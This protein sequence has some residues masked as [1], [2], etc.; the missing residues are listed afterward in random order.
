MPQENT[1]DGLLRKDIVLYPNIL[2]LKKFLLTVHHGWFRINGL[3][4]DEKYSLADYLLDEERLIIDFTR[5]SEQSRD[6][7]LKW[8][9]V[10]HGRDAHQELLSGVTTNNYRGYTA[11]VGLSWWGKVINLLFYRRKSYHWHLASYDSSLNHQITGLEVCQDAHGLLIGLK[12][13]AIEDKGEK[14]HET[15]DNQIEPLR[16]TKR[17]LITDD[18][19]DK[20]L[21]TDLSSCDFHSMVSQPHPFSIGVLSN[22]QRMQAMREYRQTQRLFSA[23]PWYERLWDWMKALFEEM[24]Q[25]IELEEIHSGSKKYHLL[26]S[27]GDVQVFKRDKDGHILVIEK[28]PE[29]SSRVFCGGGAKIFAHVGA[30]K[31]FEEVGIKPSQHAGSSAGAIMAVLCYLGYSSNDILTFFQW[32]KQDNLIHYDIDSSGLS[33][34]RAMKAALD[35]MITK[36]VNEIIKTYEVDKT[37]EG[38]RFL[39][40]KVFKHGKITFESLHSLKQRIPECSLGDK[41]IVTAT[42][43]ERRKTRYFS[44]ATTPWMEVSEAVK[45]SASFPLVFKPTI[46]EGAKHKDGGILNNLPTEAFR[47]DLSTFL[48][49]EHGNCLSMVAFQFDNGYERGLLDK[50][51]DRVYRE[52]FFWNWIYGLLTGVRDPVSGWERDRLKLLQHSNQ[53]VLIPVGNVSSTQFDLDQDTQNTLVDNGYKAAKNYINVRYNVD[54][55]S[56]KNEEHM[57]S[58]FASI[59]E[60][61]C[62]CCYRGHGTW[63]ERVALEARKE[64]VEEQKIKQLRNQHFATCE[65]EKSNE[66]EKKASEN[67]SFIK[68]GSI[69]EKQWVIRN[70][71]LF[72]AIYP[73]FHKLSCAFLTTPGDINLFK[74]ARHS[75]SLNRPLAG[76]KYLREIKGE[77]HVLLAMFIQILNTSYLEKIEEVVNKLKVLEV[78]LQNPQNFEELKKPEFYDKWHLLP[79]QNNRILKLL[80]TNNWLKARELCIALKQGEEPLETIMIE[81]PSLEGTEDGNADNR[82]FEGNRTCFGV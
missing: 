75:L 78:V 44:Y 48:E 3:S 11:E 59:E 56:A 9:L 64:G 21:A 45:T 81:N 58:T 35:Y 47:G 69:L 52:N 54:E 25:E 53:V 20:L 76:L 57:Y 17:V 49:S 46:V 6:K 7:F 71:Q 68:T 8:F 27:E 24:P 22:S 4:P 39:A 66:K 42:N 26:F 1:F 65:K 63:F 50:F 23:K 55:G 34:A 30:I 41:L 18:M 32:F 37:P 60:L 43:V 51:V 74:L 31:A 16:N 80:S 61:L 67:T 36:K 10:P 15:N 40:D 19:V 33:D 70:M 73:I 62:F 12:Q 28:R 14:Y 82:S 79:R 5:L 77:Q 38:R 13:F 72:E 29:L 2:L